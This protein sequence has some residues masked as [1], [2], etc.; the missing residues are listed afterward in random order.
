MNRGLFLAL[1]VL[2]ATVGGGGWWWWTTQRPVPVEWQGYAEA[3]FVKI[4]PTQQGMLTAV[5]VAR[6]DHVEAGAPLFDQDDTS[7]R[8]ARDQAERQLGEST[9]QLANLQA[10]ERDTEIAQ[11]EANL[12]D[13]EASRDRAQADLRRMDA[14]L[15]SGGT[16]IQTRDQAR[17]DFLSAAAKVRGLQAA[18][19]QARAPTGRAQQII[20]QTAAADALRAAIAMADWRLAQRHVTAPTAGVIADVLAR[21]GETMDAGAPVV[22]LLPP[23]N[24]FIRFFVPETMLPGVHHGDRVALICDNCPDGLVGTISFIAPQAEYTPPVIYSDQNRA[25][26]VYMLEARPR[27]DQATLFNPGQPVTVRPLAP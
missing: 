27:P 2:A 24:I 10:P 11:A 25:K 1:L 7:D 16:T 17:A 18:L 8:A 21:T 5:R 9:G 14:V 13:A 22:S 20:A 4:G 12:A 23:G 26:L 15:P 6:G 19:A 3:D